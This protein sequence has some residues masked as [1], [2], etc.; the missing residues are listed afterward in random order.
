MG[1]EGLGLLRAGHRPER[2]EGA[3]EIPGGRLR[4]RADHLI[5]DP[6]R[7][8][9]GVDQLAA[10]LPAQEAHAE[11]PEE[12]SEPH[13]PAE[14]RRREALGRAAVDRQE[15]RDEVGA[16]IRHPKRFRCRSRMGDDH[17]SP[18]TERVEHCGDATRL[19]ARRIIRVRRAARL[20]DREGLYHDRAVPGLEKHRHQVAE[21]VR[22]AEEAG[23]EDDRKSR[24]GQ[25]DVQG[26]RG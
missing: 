18:H 5:G 1:G 2:P 7:V 12:R 9:G 24:T 11:D 4:V 23:N 22:G 21:A 3:A 8:S 15:R 20:P 17:G 19:R 14:S 16:P 26:L 13:R 25:L 6:A 10:N